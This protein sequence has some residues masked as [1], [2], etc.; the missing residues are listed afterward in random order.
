MNEVQKQSCEGVLSDAECAKA[1]LNM[2]NNK[3]PGSDGLTTEFYKIFWRDLR[4]YYTDSINYSYE[5]GSLTQLQ[6]QGIINVIPK[7]DKELTN[8]NNWRPLS[9]LNTDYKIATKTIA[10]RI[11]DVLPTI[12]QDSQTG[13]MK[14]RYIGENIRLIYDTIDYVNEHN[15][16]GLLFFADFE[17]AFDSLDHT[18]MLN[19]L[20]HFNFGNSLKRWIEVFYNDISGCVSN[21]GHMSEFF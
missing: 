15:K 13:F 6:K 3:S 12:I 18:F 1:L 4:K 21:N 5:M 10:N 20:S 14:N 19:C 11:K 16:P 2:K 17:K 8:L 9:L 7:K